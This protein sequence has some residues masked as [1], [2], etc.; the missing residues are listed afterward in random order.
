[1][2]HADA[3]T[4]ATKKS[5]SKPAKLLR[6]LGA[7]IDPRAYLHAIKIINFYNYSHVQPMRRIRCGDDPA[8]SP[9]ASFTNAERIEIGHRVR[10]GSRCSLWAGPRNGR[11]T[12]GDDV[13]FGP[14][15]F[16]TA[17]NYRF[18]EGS[19]VTKQAMDEGD[20][21]IGND[22][23]LGARVMVLP[24]VTIG[25]YAVVGAGSIVTK[26]IPSAA[27]AVGAP[28]RVVSTRTVPGLQ[29][30]TAEGGGQKAVEA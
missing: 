12:L 3:D 29:S 24:G 18:N 25:D 26:D 10:I 13:L 6:L 5:L 22:V 20:I 17:A 28:A 30:G 23:W 2:N 4:G 9:D 7:M 19:P 11:I 1:M 27:I 16:L 15:V 21:T 14:E 8:I